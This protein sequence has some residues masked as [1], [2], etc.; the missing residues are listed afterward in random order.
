[1]D[2]INQPP[3]TNVDAKLGTGWQT[4]FNTTTDLLNAL[5]SSGTTV[6]RPTKNLYTGRTYFDT[7]LG[8]PIWYRGTVWVNAS[9]G[10]V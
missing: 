3:F 2:N 9:G 6:Q 1:M 8:I 5:T 10:V 4:Y 7:T